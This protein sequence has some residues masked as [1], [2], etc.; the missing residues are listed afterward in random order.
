MSKLTFDEAGKR[1]YE[2]GIDQCVLYVMSGGAYPLG[3]AWN[4]ITKISEKPT[5]A[6]AKALYA[7]NIKYLNLVSAEE[8]EASIE[9]YTYPEEWEQC[10][11]SAGLGSIDGITVGQQD[12]KTFGLAYRT[13]IGND[14][15]NKYYKYHLIYGCV[16]Q[17]SE[18][19]YSTVNDSPEAISFSWDVKTTPVNVTGMKPTACVTIDSRKLS[20]ARKA[21]LEAAL[22]GTDTVGQTQGTDPYL[23]TPNDLIALLGPITNT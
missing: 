14:Q 10:D 7:D 18:R 17:P 16:A 12:R 21:A 5:G 4:G 2:T 6:E 22:Y 23:P 9:A 15:S 1:Y 11:G 13:I 8:F 19:A 3:V 20:A